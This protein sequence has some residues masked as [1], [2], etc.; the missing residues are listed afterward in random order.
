MTHKSTHASLQKGKRQYI[1]RTK[2]KKDFVIFCNSLVRNKSLS[3]KARGMLTMA[4]SHASTFQVHL[5]SLK[6]PGLGQ[7]DAI[8]TGMQE[9]EQ[10]G[11]AVYHQECESGRFV[12]AYW[13]FHDN[14]VDGKELT[15][16][17]K[18]ATGKWKPGSF[19]PCA[20]KPR[21]GE[22]CH[23]ESRHGKAAPKKT[24]GQKTNNIKKKEEKMPGSAEAHF[25]SSFFGN[26][27]ANLPDSSGVADDHQN[28]NHE[29]VVDDG[30]SGSSKKLSP[31][32]TLEIGKNMTPE[33]EKVLSAW[34]SN[35]EIHRGVPYTGNK[36]D[37]EGIELLQKAWTETGA[38]IA[39]IEKAF[40]LFG[41]PEAW[42]C[43]NRMDLIYTAALNFDKISA[44]IAKIPIEEYRWGR[45]EVFNEEKRIRDEFARATKFLADRNLQS[46]TQ[47][48]LDFLGS[49]E[50]LDE[51]S[52]YCRC[53]LGQESIDVILRHGAR[54]YVEFSPE[55][56][57]FLQENKWQMCMKLLKELAEEEAENPMYPVH[58]YISASLLRN[59]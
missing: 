30:E 43:N 55:I 22:S 36:S 24:K 37:L 5:S 46:G 19:E 12:N 16:R 50:A 53:F 34:K 39:Q 58:L 8:H 3:H 28:N 57:K 26:P 10:A 52:P 9:L 41:C 32:K 56:E 18:W 14:P 31:V 29:P 45:A 15:N 33:Q 40:L 4:L 51:V 42:T 20:V 59:G 44:E 6:G 27:D 25:S 21:H 7:H 49:E 54:A 35:F 23:G 17:T 48:Y 13:T 38:L 1:F 47:A 11:Y 2:P